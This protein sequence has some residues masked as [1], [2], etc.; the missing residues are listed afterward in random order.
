[1]PLTTLCP[2]EVSEIELTV[3]LAKSLQ[4]DLLREAGVR[5]KGK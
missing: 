5:T 2:T 3:A 1:M 4:Q